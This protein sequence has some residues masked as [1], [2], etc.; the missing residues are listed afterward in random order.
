[1]QAQHSHICMEG[2]D[3]DNEPLFMEVRHNMEVR[4]KNTRMHMHKS[5]TVLS[6]PPSRYTII[7]VHSEEKKNHQRALICLRKK[8]SSCTEIKTNKKIG[9]KAACVFLQNPVEWQKMAICQLRTSASS[10]RSINFNTLWLQRSCKREDRSL[11]SFFY[12]Y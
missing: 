11:Y 5:G 8:S 4:P 10:Y 7:S 2:L 12:G 3:R 6:N 9:F 1:M